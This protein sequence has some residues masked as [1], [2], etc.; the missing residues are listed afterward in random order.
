MVYLNDMEG[1]ITKIN[2]TSSGTLFEQQT[3]MNLETDFDNQ[4]L[5]YFEMDATLG[6]SSGNLWLFGGTGDFN[7]IS[8]TVGADGKANMDNIVYGIRDRDFPF[9]KPSAI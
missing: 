9:V 6:A 8:D 2:L 3:L 4:R 1:K 5:S 7:R